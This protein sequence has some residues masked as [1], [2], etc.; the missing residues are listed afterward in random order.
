VVVVVSRRRYRTL[1]RICGPTHR[2][3]P[4]RAS[5][6]VE[7]IAGQVVLLGTRRSRGAH[8]AQQYRSTPADRW[9][10]YIPAPWYYQCVRPQPRL[11]QPWEWPPGP[12]QR[13][14]VTMRNLGHR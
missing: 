11:L 3:E 6:G 8:R 5:V 10:A 9:D 14:N 13:P 2:A 1:G 12:A 7:Q 4:Y